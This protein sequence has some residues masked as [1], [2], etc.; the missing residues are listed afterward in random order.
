MRPFA[1]RRLKKDSPLVET[2]SA[3][4]VVFRANGKVLL[5]KREDE[6]RWC[7]PKG[8]VEEGEAPEQAALRE[9]SEETGLYCDLAGHVLDIRYQYHWP[10]DG[11]NYDKTVKYYLAEVIGGGLKLE[12]GFSAYRWCTEKE[13]LRLLHYDNDKKVVKRAYRKLR[14]LRGT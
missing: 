2:F 12:R 13:A 8:G 1:T 5:L 11:V 10:A 6:K 7:L 9:I 4:G 3:G 14:R